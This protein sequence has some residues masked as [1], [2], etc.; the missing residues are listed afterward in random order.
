MVESSSVAPSTGPLGGA[1]PQG[2]AHPSR[3]IGTYQPSL[4]G[5]RWVA[6]TIMLAFHAGFEWGQGAAFSLSQFFT[7]SGFLITSLL[8]RNRRADGR[9]DL[10]QFWTKRIRRL[11]PAALLVLGGIVVFAV[12]FADGS[13]FAKLPG[14]VTSAVFYVVNWYFVFTD[15]SYVAQLASPS[16]VVHF[17][18][19]SV[20]EQ[21]YIVMPLVLLLLLRKTTSMRVLTAV[22]AGAAVL[23]AVWMVTLNHLGAS[24][25][26]LYYGTDTRAAE[27]LVGAALGAWLYGRPLRPT[28]LQRR[29]LAVAGLVVMAVTAWLWANVPLTDPWLYRGGFFAFSLLSVVLITSLLADAGPLPRILSWGPLPALGRITYGVY[30]IQWPV[31]LWIDEERTGLSRWP[32]L[33][34]QLAIIMGLATLMYHF[35]EL[36]IR[37]GARIR[38]SGKWILAPTVA[39]GICV[40]AIVVG[41]LGERA[42]AGDDPLRTVAGEVG[43]PPEVP[44]DPVHLLVIADE[45]GRGL[46]DELAAEGGEAG[47]DVTVADFACR[48]ATVE[49]T[50]RCDDWEEAWPALVDEVRPDLVLFSVSDWDRETIQQLAGD[51]DP[52]V[53]QVAFWTEQMLGRGFDLLSASGAPVVWAPI[54]TGDLRQD[55]VEAKSPLRGSMERLLRA[56][57]DLRELT[58]IQPAR[59]D[60]PTAVVQEHAVE[61]LFSDLRTFVPHRRD[62]VPRVM[63]V[64]D[65]AARSLGWGLERWANESQQAVVWNAATNGCGLVASGQYVS[66][67]GE[68]S[69]LFPQCKEAARVRR[70]QVEEFDPDVVIVLSSIW[71]MADRI[72]PGTDQPVRPGDDAFDDFVLAAY[73]AAVDDFA[74]RGAT[75]LWMRVPCAGYGGTRVLGHGVEN[76]DPFED[77]RVEHFNEVI[78]PELA[79][80]R[81]EVR[82]Y[83]LFGVLCPDGTFV[84]DFGDGIGNIRPDGVHFDPDGATWLARTYGTEILAAAN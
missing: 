32:T 61:Q 45:R 41:T 30:L 16:P 82:F 55:V 84:E 79:E 77:D 22:F 29:V 81:P 8:L 24:I 42:T 47:Y 34:L 37:S 48:A 64:G 35:V 53:G 4:D 1:P 31:F 43:A 63:V 76:T 78:L 54:G 59:M 21:F 3:A 14:Q 69:D 49:A 13:Q 65:S 72:L 60:G 28:A 10:R 6:M 40:A 39:V 83:D 70:E 23:S 68:P 2:A 44:R 9:V 17:W 26:R 11:M 46:A 71:D 56:R 74:S 33:V 15:Q 73:E 62:D 51:P 58:A 75:V 7:L 36:P 18:S 20:E 52:P 57:D 25:D 19:L 80:S 38:G 66:L 50:M 27:F 12:P 5:L 67:E